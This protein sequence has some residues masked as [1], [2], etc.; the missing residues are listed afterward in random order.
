MLRSRLLIKS[1]IVLLAVLAVTLGASCNTRA[2]E[3]LPPFEPPPPMPGPPLPIDPPMPWPPE[4]IPPQ[5]FPVAVELYQVSA[6]VD[7]PVASVTVKQIFRN[8]SART[9]EGTY[10][11]PLPLDALP[12]S[13]QLLIDGEMVEGQM[14]D[15]D[16]AR[17]IY[18]NIVRRERDPALLEFLGNGLFQINVF[19]IPAGST[20]TVELTYEHAVTADNGLYQFVAPLRAYVA[21]S[22]AAEVVSVGVKLLN[23]DGLR[24]IYSPSHDISIE[25]TGDDSALI[26]FEG[27]GADTQSDFTLYFGTDESAIG[28]NLIS[29][30]PAGEDGYFMLLVAPSLEAGAEQVVERDLVLVLDVSGSMQGTKIKQARE[31][32]RFVVSQLNEGDRFNLI[33]FSTGSRLWQRDLQEVNSATVA[34]AEEWIDRIAASG[35]TDINRAL[36]EAMNQF[37]SDRTRPAYIIFMTDGQPT[38]GETDPEDILENALENQPRE[39]SLRLFAFGVGFDV[40]TD[41]LNS[42]SSD[43]GG[44]AGYVKPDQDIEEIVGD[45]A[46]QIAKPVLS[47]VGLGLGG[48]MVVDELYPFPLTD[49]FAGEQLL[50]V[51]R[52]RNGGPVELEITGNVNGEPITYVYPGEV[53]EERGG[54]PF[55]ARLWATRKIGALLAQIRREGYNQELVDAVIELSL[56]YGIVSPF[57]SY[58]VLEPGMGSAEPLVMEAPA[59]LSAPSLRRDA[60]PAAAAAA[61]E[62]AAAPAAGEGAVAAAEA[63]SDLQ[64]AQTVAEAEQVRYLEGKSF[65]RR[66]WVNDAD[67]NPV[68]FWVD[69]AVEEGVTPEVVEFASER[70]FELV[71]D[72]TVARW[73]SLSPEMIVVIEGDT[74]RITTQPQ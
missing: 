8:D 62:L 48:D 67:G 38:M 20:R 69:T 59:A 26:G 43:L 14:Y 64:S 50:V 60:A 7:G 55:I 28:A 51:G 31:A 15:R 1:L 23:Q 65:V 44:R 37:G 54:E 57:T 29:Y 36:L 70:Y 73:L 16:E 49:L 6:V 12:S 47:D 34:D 3:P 18:E 21:G 2:Q 35:S 68:E 61:E 71:E 17:S 40:N 41:L 27:R 74:I 25:R 9:V 11:F 56:E 32:A 45:F 10:I 46:A 13:L 30:K 53:L 24:T 19:P 58:L 22:G 63:R 52:Y 66:G 4:P 5:N 42:L 33:T 72:D 39:R